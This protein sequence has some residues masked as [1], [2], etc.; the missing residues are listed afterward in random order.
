MILYGI[1][2]CDSVK[3]ARK[4]LEGNQIDYQFHDFKKQGINVE[5]IQSWLAKQPLEKIVNKRSTSWKQLCDEQKASLLSGNLTVLT[6]MPTLIKR[7]VLVTDDT[8]HL[9]F[10]EVFYQSLTA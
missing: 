5:T 4:A 9:G 2:N 7:P 6:E 3:Q 10:D 8:V 1:L